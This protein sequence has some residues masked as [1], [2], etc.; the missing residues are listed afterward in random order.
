MCMML[1]SC[2]DIHDDQTIAVVI[3]KTEISDMTVEMERRIEG[4]PLNSLP[5]LTRYTQS[6]LLVDQLSW[7]TL[8]CHS[9]RLAGMESCSL[10]RGLQPISSEV[11]DKGSRT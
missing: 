8:D 2:Q 9:H 11:H 4:V 5:L 6:V 1:T 7:V 3:N 10:N